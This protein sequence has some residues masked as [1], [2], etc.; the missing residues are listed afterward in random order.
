M[1][2]SLFLSVFAGLISLANV[3]SAR[4]I[5]NPGGIRTQIYSFS[6]KSFEGAD[7]ELRSMPNINGINNN[8]PLNVIYI[9]SDK[10]EVYIEGDRNLFCRVQT[11]YKNGIVSISLDPGTYRNLWLQVVVYAP[12]MNILKSTGSG[13]IKAEKV[14]ANAGEASVKVTGSAIIALGELQCTSDLDLHISGSGDI[15]IENMTCRELDV[16]VTGSGDVLA[17]GTTS[18]TELDCHIAG[19]G[20]TKFANVK[21]TSAEL[22]VTGSGAIK[23]TDGTFETIKARI[24]GS[25]DISGDVKCPA[26]DRKTAGSGAIRLNAK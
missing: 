2:K 12:K 5:L 9:E 13:N 15:R 21:G 17:N 1:K 18:C 4:D 10:S 14:S 25:G 19:S 22:A 16:N 8:G 6:N 11:Q 3:A 26:I 7:R 24:T 23:I 20:G